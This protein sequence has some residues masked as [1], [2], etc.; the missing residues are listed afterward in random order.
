[1]SRLAI[2]IIRLACAAVA[3]ALVAVPASAQQ[4]TMPQDSILLTVFLKHDQSKTVDQINEQLK[5][6][7]Y[8][9]KFPPQGIEVVSWYVMMGIGQ[10]V[11]LRVP[12]SR[13]RDVNRAIEQ[14]A[15]GAYRTE[16]YPT[17]DFKPIAEQQRKTQ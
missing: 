16:F 5:H 15:W 3:L 17:Y 9:K 10:V 2:G 11:T 12:A 13:L 6:Q 8:Y 7:D 14:S 1:M 4:A